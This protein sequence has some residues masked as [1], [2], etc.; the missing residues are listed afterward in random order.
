[1]DRQFQAKVLEKLP[2]DAG[3]FGP[4]LYLKPVDHILSGFCAEKVRNGIYISKY[5]YPLCD[6]SDD[7]NLNFSERLP[8]PECFIDFDVIDKADRANEFVNRILPFIENAKQN[9]DVHALYK[10]I[11]NN[12]NILR[13]EWVMK[14]Y[15]LLQVL[16]GKYTGALVNIEKILANQYSGAREQ[17]A[18]ECSEIKLLL[19]EDPFS[20][21]DKV[22]EWEG[23]MKSRV[24]SP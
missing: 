18:K 11:Q 17:I 6:R 5:C 10:F 9:L 15:I 21:K 2:V 19:E 1:M 12:E 24:L 20:A 7:L 22:V 3:F 23:Q 4:F 13:N 16:M 14:T 8:Y